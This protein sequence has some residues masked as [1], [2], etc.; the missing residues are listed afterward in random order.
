[1][2]TPLLLVAVLSFIAVGCQG[3]APV[4]LAADVPGTTWSVERVVLD[5]GQILRGG[6]DQVSFGPEGSLSISSC[7]LCSGRYAMEDSVLTIGEPLACT[8]RGC[9]PGALEL[10]NHLAGTS[11]VRRDG[12]YLVVRPDSLAEQ[13]LLVPASEQDAASVTDG[14]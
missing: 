7:N 5:D 11:V 4:G 10:E 8:R 13:I 3:P 2:R 9:A 1:M 6:N 12:I 14:P